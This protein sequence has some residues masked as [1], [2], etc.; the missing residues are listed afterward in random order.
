MKYIF[1]DLDGTITNPKIG[2]TKSIQY[3]LASFGIKEDNL[4]NLTRHIGPPLIDTFREYYG[5]DENKTKLAVMKFKE[6]FEDIGWCENEVYEGM[7]DMLKA[8][9]LAVKT[10]IVATSKPEYMAKKI[11]DHFNLSQYFTDICGSERDGSRSKKHEVIQYAIDK[12]AIKNK[13]DIIMVGD[14]SYDIL[15]AK[16]VGI[17]SIGV[18]YGFGCLTE[19]E[20]ANADFIVQTVSELH[21]VVLSL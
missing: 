13:E 10:L 3:S 15:G 20:D 6:R 19:F 9:Q 17:Q 12:N 14:R 2:I 11:L 5:F 4:D 21:D 8:F 16:R 7:E 1:M 18:L